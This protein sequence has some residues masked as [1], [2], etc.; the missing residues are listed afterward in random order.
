MYTKAFEKIYLANK[1]RRDSAL[2]IVKMWNFLSCLAGAD[3]TLGL[4][5]HVRGRFNI[6]PLELEDSS[7]LVQDPPPDV[8]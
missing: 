2:R 1:V 6:L 3:V 8:R 4:N 5:D 7:G